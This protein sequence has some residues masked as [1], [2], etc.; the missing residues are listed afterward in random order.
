MLYI[1]C[2]TQHITRTYS[3]SQVFPTCQTLSKVLDTTF[4]LTTA[5]WESTASY[6]PKKKLRIGEIKF[7]AQGHRL[8]SLEAGLKH[9]WPSTSRQNH[10]TPCFSYL[11]PTPPME[12]VRPEETPALLWS[13]CHCLSLERSRPSPPAAL[14]RALLTP[15]DPD[16]GLCP[17]RLPGQ[18]HWQDG[19][20]P[21]ENIANVSSTSPAFP[22]E[23]NVEKTLLFFFSPCRS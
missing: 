11:F 19:R 7:L 20:G 15:A 14:S 13:P 2:D 12:K 21:N 8:L 6:F 9:V 18:P 10:S 23:D 5:P 22:S 3:I 4:I 1:A 16:T 17:S